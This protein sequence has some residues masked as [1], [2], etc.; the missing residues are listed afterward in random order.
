MDLS[1]IDFVVFIG[2][3]CLVVGLGLF[4]SRRKKGVEET[5]SDYFL[6]SRSLPW[7]AVGASL[8]ASNI[9]AE[10][11]IGMSGSGFAIGLGIATYEW[12]GAIGLLIVAKFFLP[13]FLKTKIYTMPQFLEIRFDH[14]V[15]TSLAV[16]WLLV[17][18]FVNLTSVLYLGALV[19]VNVMGITL[20]QAII[21]LAAFSAL[22]SVYGGLKAVAW[23]DVMQVT[24][25][26]V[27]GLITTFLVLGE[28]GQGEGVLAGFR[29]MLDQAPEKFD[30][31][32]A[33]DH[34]MYTYLPGIGVLLG[35]IWMANLYYFGCNQYI[36]QRALAAK[37]LKE[38]QRGV[39]FAGFLKVLLPVLVVV[40]GIAAYVLQADIARA[41]DA[42][43][44]L[45]SNF[46]G[47]GMK[48][49]VFAALIAAIVSSLSSM[50]NS[51][52]TIFTMDL[53]KPLMNKAASEKK[54]VM[55]GRITSLVVL[56]IA[57]SIAPL[58]QNLDQ[59]FQF[60]QDFTG[61]VT[62]GLVAIFL[63]GLFWKKATANAALLVAILT[64]PLSLLFDLF[65]PD[66][67]F[68]NRVGYCFLILSGILVAYSL[69]ENRRKGDQGKGIE[70]EK[71][72]FKTGPVFN[73][74]AIIILGVLAAL[75]AIFW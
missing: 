32:L 60:I 18:V 59:A 74:S 51:S 22:Y 70:I 62:P 75:Y 10:Q 5:S 50:T 21:G 17:Y 45:L 49:L 11:F 48:G 34:P 72:L 73:G 24:F 27:G 37:S 14:R 8:I 46:V 58:L 15:R 13:I 55:T 23:T 44:W 6:A 56:A 25:L 35:G 30:M 19:L 7:W 69:W 16:F 40:P 42:Y 28:I 31:V 2:Y 47:P 71:G 54:L 36:I 12:V 9:S 52:S 4:V 53:Y 41:D 3:C 1:T 33:K 63:A 43:P 20:I 29:N 26:V 64:I 38:A 57:V 61:Y 66:M 39:A 65:I 68:M 67:P